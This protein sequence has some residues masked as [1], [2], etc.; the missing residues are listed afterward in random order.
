M[1][2]ATSADTT[3][4][5]WISLTSAAT[6]AVVVGFASTILV[7]M[8]GARAVGAT[9]AQQA[10]TAA[11]LCFAM[12]VTSFILAV[13][14]KQPIM[15][16]WSTPGSA[17]MATGAAGI[18]FPDAIGA[19]VFAGALMMLTA[20]IK[21]L[22]TA[23][24]R[25]PSAIAAAI[26][27]GVLLRFVLGVPNAALELPVFVVPLIIAFFALRMLVPMFTVPVVVALGLM[28]AGLGGTFSGP[29]HIGITPMTFDWPQ[30]NWQVILGL[31]VPLY[32]VTMA[33]QNLPGFAV[34][35]AHGYQ[36][37]VG[38]SLLVT[39]LGSMLT[40][41]FGAHAIN[42]A[43]IT[44]ALVAGPD[45]HPDSSQRWKMVFP[46]AALYV[47]FGLAAGTFVSLLGAMP[48]PLIT[49]VAGL[50][51]FSPLIAGMT[52]MVKEPKDIEAAAVTFLVTASGITV[53]GV[54]AAF[55][56]LLAGLIVWATKRGLAR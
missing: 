49:A 54:G 8:E 21:P 48:K 4:K 50:A 25:M 35:K 29:V 2:D 23:I 13:R 7:V 16:A 11:V 6:A 17:L 5:H 51:L 10:S 9:P 42:M 30:W 45:A 43:A 56:G 12:A 44:A 19:F 18:A 20:L 52:S 47:V 37:P 39:G 26:V 36:P 31:G 41:P 33:S 28:F 55:W 32:L 27:A 40:A 1:T 24:S 34:L 3:M 38:P 15:V 22:S 53:L 46:Y 14:Y